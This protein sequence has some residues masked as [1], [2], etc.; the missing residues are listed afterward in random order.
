MGHTSELDEEAYA[1]RILDAWP[2]SIHQIC[3]GAPRAYR[4]WPVA[5]PSP[6]GPLG[7]Q[8]SPA[9]KGGRLRPSPWRRDRRER[10]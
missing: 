8:R 3:G 5:W 4:A 10:P 2:Q 6:S 9:L 7:W 1:V